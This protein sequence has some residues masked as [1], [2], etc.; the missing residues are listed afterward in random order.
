M[1]SVT[2]DKLGNTRFPISRLLIWNA[3][4]YLAYKERDESNQAMLDSYIKRKEKQDHCHLLRINL[5]MIAFQFQDYWFGIQD[6]SRLIRNGTKVTRQY[7]IPIEGKQNRYW[8]LM[9]NLA[10]LAFQYKEYWFGIQDRARLIRIQLAFH[11]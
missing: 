3:R 10:M 5:A 4:S 6:R 9:I 8:L 7:L 11:D 2:H 1:L